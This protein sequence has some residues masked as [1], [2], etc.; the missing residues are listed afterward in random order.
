DQTHYRQVT[1]LDELRALPPSVAYLELRD[2]GD[3]ATLLL[4]GR[5]RLRGVAYIGHAPDLSEGSLRI[6]GEMSQLEELRIEVPKWSGG[7]LEHH[8]ALV[9]LRKLSLLSARAEPMA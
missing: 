4:A 5:E 1:T 2:L 6:L 8:G 9:N 7:G 3:Q